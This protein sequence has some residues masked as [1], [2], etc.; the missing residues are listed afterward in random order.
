[1]K[2]IFLFDYISSIF[3]FCCPFCYS[4]CENIF[5]TSTNLG[6][7]CYQCKELLTCIKIIDYYKLLIFDTYYFNNFSSKCLKRINKIKIYAFFLQKILSKEDFYELKTTFEEFKNILENCNEDI[8]MF[9]TNILCLKNQNNKRTRNDIYHFYNNYSKNYN[10]KCNQ[11]YNL[12][13]S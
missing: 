2:T 8:I 12:I 3:Y 1:M 9:E 11:C 5:E 7:W 13:K 6:F 10:L 4:F